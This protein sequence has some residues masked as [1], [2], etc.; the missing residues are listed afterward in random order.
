MLPINLIKKLFF[1]GV[2]VF[3]VSLDYVLSQNSS[4]AKINSNNNL[5]SLIRLTNSLSSLAS[6]SAKAE[7]L[8]N[9]IKFFSDFINKLINK[10]VDLTVPKIIHYI[11]L[12]GPIYEEYWLTITKMATIARANGYIVWVW[13]D[14]SKNLR[15]LKTI[16]GR[17]RLNIPETT[18]III[19]NDTYDHYINKLKSIEIKS[20]YDLER[21]TKALKNVPITFHKD[22]WKALR[23]EMVGLK[24][25][26][27]A[28][29]LLR[30]LILFIYGGLYFDTDERIVSSS[31]TIPEIGTITLPCGFKNNWIAN[32]ILISIREHPLLAYTLLNAIN[33]LKKL[34]LERQGERR[35]FSSKIFSLRR[36]LTIELTGPGILVSSKKLFKAVLDELNQNY[37]FYEDMTLNQL[38]EKEE[39]KLLG[40]EF[41][42]YIPYL[43]KIGKNLLIET[44]SHATWLAGKNPKF[45]E[46]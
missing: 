44:R 36:D 38:N 12:G 23:E 2:L 26:G 25:Y 45:V 1:L 27:A 19:D 6:L 14:N 5:S 35:K 34:T 10:K 20:I 32:S 33:E 9:P 8:M 29:D 46:E 28:S 7:D 40:K 39:K 21:Q 42:K 24:N 13:V 18:R 3:I 11:W 15:L 31:L 30:Y 41:K 4:K 43:F 16:P 37:S 17:L 22:F